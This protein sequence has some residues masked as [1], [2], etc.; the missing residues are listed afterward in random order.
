M[1]I[2][3]SK[4]KVIDNSGADLVECIKIY[5]KKQVGSLGDF[6]LIATPKHR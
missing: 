5:K 4:L 1:L 2:L 6:I 3:K